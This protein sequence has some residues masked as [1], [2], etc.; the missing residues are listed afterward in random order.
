[1]AF[2][3]L[4]TAVSPIAPV[5]KPIPQPYQT[6]RNATPAAKRPRK[7]PAPKDT[8][9]P[10]PD[11]PANP[12]IAPVDVATVSDENSKPVATTGNGQAEPVHDEQMDAEPMPP[13]LEK[14]VIVR[15]LVDSSAA[16]RS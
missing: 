15:A 8:D 6:V 13:P 7:E 16:N 4:A 11:A 2:N 14:P 10:M 3:K 1:M 12:P 5:N 9:E